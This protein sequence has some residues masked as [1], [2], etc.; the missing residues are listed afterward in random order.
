SSQTQT[1]IIQDTIAPVLDIVELPTITA[2]CEITTLTKP[3]ATDNCTG[4]VT[5]SH[6]V[7]LPINTQGTTIIT[8]TFEDGN[9]NSSS[10]TQNIII[11]QDTT[12]PVL[13]IVELPTITAQCEIITLTKPTS[14]DNCA[15]TVTAS[16]DI[17]LPITTPGTTIITWTFED[18]NGNSS[19]QTQK[20]IIQDT[21]APVLDIVELPTIT[22]QC[23]IT[24]LTKPT[25]SDNCTGTVT[26][27]HDVTLPIT[28]QGSTIITWTFEDGNGNSSSQTQMII[29]Q[30]TTDPL[31][32]VSELPTITAQCEIVSLTNPT[33]T[34]NCIGTVTPSHNTTL[35][36]NTQGT[37]IITWTFEDDNGNSSSQTQT[38]IIEDTTAPV[39]DIVELPILSAQCEITTLTKPT[40]TDYCA[41]TVIAS[42]DITLPI[43]TQGTTIINWTFKDGNGNSSSQTQT[44]IIEDTTAPI[45]DEVFLSDISIPINTEIIRPTATDNCQ[46]EVKTSTFDTTIFT[47]PGNFI[48]IWFYTDTLGN[49]NSQ[50]Q[51]VTVLEN[52]FKKK[53]NYITPNDDGVNDYLILKNILKFPENSVQIYSRNGTLI[54]KQLN[55][56]QDWDGYGNIKFRELVPRGIYY[57]IINFKGKNSLNSV[58]WVYV[59]Y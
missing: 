15:G 41:G 27:S 30:F 25:A 5:A 52:T 6:D 29:I 17:T 23:E 42:H 46:Q 26:A 10:Q 48:I 43:N 50:K 37:T 55:A 21:T 47:S 22:A 57:Y 24:T 45:A 34:D 51:K 53:H 40:A 18:G 35:P 16:H 7:T 4:T 1:I 38:I 8:W 59:D 11:I 58:G 20:I 12:A 14:T 49:Q 33:T 3:T 56:Q 2:Q 32:D 9:G 54:Y 36:I 28:T 44:I 19:S 13:D 39:L 31:L